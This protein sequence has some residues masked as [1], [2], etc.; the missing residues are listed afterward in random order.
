FRAGGGAAGHDFAAGLQRLHALLP[1]SV[2]HVL[3]NDVAHG[4][5]GDVLHFL[6]DLLLVVI[7]GM[8]GA[9]LARLVHLVLV[10]GGGNDRGA[11]HF[12]DLDGSRSDARASTQHQHRVA[13]FDSSASHQHVPGSEKHKRNGGGLVVRQ[14][15]LD[16]QNID[17]GHGDELGV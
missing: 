5:V 6:G 16:G 12:G 2:A 4:A 1:G 13:G 11:E 14:F 8:V 9:E 3:K 7:D 17:A 10:A 15:A